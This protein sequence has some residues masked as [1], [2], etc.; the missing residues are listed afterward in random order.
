MATD[1]PAVD[2]AV[3]KA[4]APFE[5]KITWN[6]ETGA[7][8]ISGD[9]G[10]PLLVMEAIGQA[11]CIYSEKAQLARANVPMIAAPPGVIA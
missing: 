10:D 11:M 7:L 3:K 4:L 8:N 2:A 6:R 9:T 5:L 1:N